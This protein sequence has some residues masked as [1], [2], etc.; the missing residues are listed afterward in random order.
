MF[1]VLCQEDH[2]LFG[3]LGCQKPL[4]EA[5]TSAVG[6]GG[7]VDL[8][9]RPTGSGIEVKAKMGGWLSRSLFPVL[10]PPLLTLHSL[11]PGR[12][13]R[14]PRLLNDAVVYCTWA[15]KRFAHGGRA[16]YS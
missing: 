13:T 8:D 2:N 10:V 4:V 14:S 6:Q 1:R 16:E 15:G 11:F 5:D 12:T 9:T 7:G 3:S